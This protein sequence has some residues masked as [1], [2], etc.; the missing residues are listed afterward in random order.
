MCNYLVA[1]IFGVVFFEAQ[2]AVTGNEGK[3]KEHP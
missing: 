2:K 1:Q 3:K